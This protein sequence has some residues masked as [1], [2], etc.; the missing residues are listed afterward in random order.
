MTKLAAFIDS[1]THNLSLLKEL[2]TTNMEAKRT[3]FNLL[4][5]SE[6]S[7][8][9]NPHFYFRLHPLVSDY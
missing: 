6:I 4:N 3:N 8:E 2:L 9:Y 7:P 5:L 1:Q